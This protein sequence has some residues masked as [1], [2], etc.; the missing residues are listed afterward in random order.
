M[1]RKGYSTV[2]AW[3][4]A[5]SVAAAMVLNGQINLLDAFG[6][7]GGVV[8]QEAT[9]APFQTAL[10]AMI[11]PGAFLAA[12]PSRIRRRNKERRRSSWQSC[13]R[14]FACGLAMII[15]AGIAGGGD[16][17][18]LSGLAQGSLAA[19]AFAACAWLAGLA[20]A[21]LAEGRRGA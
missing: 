21:R 14:C 11:I 16:G 19:Y 20:V 18:L 1:A 4:L 8:G 2:G 9:A 10:A 7:A 3:L 6:Q 5:L 15:G 12:L 13:L 17:L